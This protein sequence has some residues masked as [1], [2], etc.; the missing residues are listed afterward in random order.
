MK[1]K[2]QKRERMMHVRMCWGQRMRQNFWKFIE[3]KRRVKRSIIKIKKNT[4]DSLDGRRI[5]VSVARNLREEIC[6][7]KYVFN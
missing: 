5:D 2:I 4:N 7:V 3:E 6:R 1:L